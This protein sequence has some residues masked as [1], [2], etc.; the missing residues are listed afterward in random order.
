MQLGEDTTTMSMTLNPVN[1][2]AFQK[3]VQSLETL[4]RAAVFHP[5]GTGKSCIAWKVVEAHPQTTFFWL[6]AG[7]QRL[8]LRQAEL[9]RYNGGTLPGNV[10]FCDCEKLAAATGRPVLP[11]HAGLPP[12]VRAANQSAFVAS[13]DTVMVA[14]VAF[15]MGID[16]PDVRFVAHLDLP[17]SVEGYYQEI[18][19]AGR[20]GAD[21]DCILFYSWADVL[22]LEVSTLAVWQRLDRWLPLLHRLCGTKR[23]V[24]QVDEGIARMEGI[25]AEEAPASPA[26]GCRPSARTSCTS[27]RSAT[28]SPS[29]R[30]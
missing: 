15:G 18:G 28:T 3:A 10:R 9:T 5:T 4:N 8:T 23:H 14:T 25:R 19:R 2:A 17:K 30:S 1:E 20:D 21:A 27:T 12:E 16:K 11:Y 7:A 13:E 22:S 24:V 26:P 29:S 6:V